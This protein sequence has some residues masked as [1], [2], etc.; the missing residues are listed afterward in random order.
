MIAAKV[1]CTHALVGVCKTVSGYFPLNPHRC[2]DA[3]FEGAVAGEHH[4][5]GSVFCNACDC[6]VNELNQLY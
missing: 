2:F 1:A 4:M 5:T 3:V 6:L